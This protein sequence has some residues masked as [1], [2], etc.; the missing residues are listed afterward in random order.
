[1]V[2]AYQKGELK[3]PP[4]RIRELA[5]RISEED[6]EHFARTKRKRLPERKSERE[7][8]AESPAILGRSALRTGRFRIVRDAD[9]ILQVVGPRGNDPDDA[10]VVSEKEV[11]RLL[12]KRLMEKRAHRAIE[13]FMEGDRY[14]APGP[15]RVYRCSVKGDKV[16]AKEI[17]N[18][19]FERHDFNL[20]AK[21]AEAEYDEALSALLRKVAAG[22]RVVAFDKRRHV[23]FKTLDEAA[24]YLASLGAVT[25]SE[26]RKM[27]SDRAGLINGMQIAYPDSASDEVD[28]EKAFGESARK[29]LS[30]QAGEKVN[31]GLIDKI[32]GI[33][34]SLG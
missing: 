25:E 22:Q 32:R 7:K 1:M 5:D 18:A 12:L 16:E 34:S 15:T 31:G 30:R 11:E 3:D 20:T 26:I 2:H 13:A 27:L 23:E 24:S 17:G 8:R 14:F 9:G 4:E 6:A 33:L 19:G 29:T 21:T 10:M 28:S